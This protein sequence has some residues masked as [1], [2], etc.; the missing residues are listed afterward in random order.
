M[1]GRLGESPLPFPCWL[2]RHDSV[3][4]AGEWVPLAL[5]PN[6]VLA[7]EFRLPDLVEVG[8]LGLSLMSSE[9]NCLN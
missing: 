2:I 1:G 9:R 7:L 3:L 5:A 8:P 6:S 4:V